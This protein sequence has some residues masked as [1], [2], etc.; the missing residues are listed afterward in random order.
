MKFY[1]VLGVVTKYCIHLRQSMEEPRNECDLWTVQGRS[2]GGLRDTMSASIAIFAFV[3]NYCTFSF[4]NGTTLHTHADS[5]ALPLPLSRRGPCIAGSRPFRISE[6]TSLPPSPF[7]PFTQYD[8]H[9]H[10]KPFV[11]FPSSKQR[12]CQQ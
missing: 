5:P 2:S 4:R 11:L 10:C 1:S 6:R 9:H 8:A 12:L 7:Y 3:Y